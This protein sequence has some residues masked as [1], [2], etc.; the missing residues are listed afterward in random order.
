MTAPVKR[1]REESTTGIAAI[2]ALRRGARLS[3]ALAACQDLLRRSPTEPRLLLLAATICRDRR[4][5][6][7]AL[8]FLDRIV[9]AKPAAADIYCEVARLRRQCG[10]KAGALDAYRD[11]LAADPASATAHA[12]LAELLTVDGQAEE[13]IYHL[14]IAIAVDPARLDA[15]ET[16]ATLME[17]HGRGTEAATLRQETMYRARRRI[18]AEYTRIRT[19][20]ASDSARALQRLRLS[21][22]HALLIFGTAG[23]GLAKFEESEGDG[24]KA[25]ETYGEVLSVLAEGAD[26]A[27]TVP[28]LRRAFATASL[29]FA[30][31]HYELALLHERR[32]AAD[33]AIFHVEE[34][35]R[36]HGSPWDDAYARLGSL[37][38]D[39]AGGITAIRQAVAGATTQPSRPAAYPITRWDVARQARPWLSEVARARAAPPG[40][41]G[42]HVA[43]LAATPDDIEVGFAIA[44]ILAAR[45][46]RIDLIW[47]PGLRFEGACDPD[48]GFDAWDETLMAQAVETLA[49]ADLP[50]GLRLVDLRGLDAADADEAMEQEADRLAALDAG[51]RRATGTVYASDRPAEVQHRNRTQRNLAA[52]RRLAGYLAGTK[53]HH[54]LLVNGDMT[55]SGCAFWV[56]RRAGCPAVVWERCP[57]RAS[58]VIVSSNR[59]RADR[60]YTSLW[61]ADEPHD[62]TPHR[63]ERAMAWLANRSGGDYRLVTPRKHYVPAP[64]SFRALADHRLDSV[65]PVVVLFGDRAADGEATREGDAFADSKT[66]ILRNI[67]FFAQHPEWQLIVRLYPQDGPSG[68]RNA[69]REKQSD[70]PRNVSFVESSDPKLDY[71]LL[72]VAQL[73]LFRTNPIGLEIAMMGV[74]AIAAGQPFF[75][76]KGFTRDTTDDESYFRTVRRALEN[77]DSIAMTDREIELAWCFADMCVHAAPKPFPWSARNFWRDVTEDW[78]LRRVLGDAGRVRFGP[79]FAALGG[80]VAL[81]DGVVGNIG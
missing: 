9:A 10:S 68:V 17:T 18:A 16:L 66:W 28:A 57:D 45:G 33:R 69:L 49:A 3:E 42:N 50:D 74:I 20:A 7:E 58:A 29:A 41:E 53:P 12:E 19:P 23:I 65:R 27:R 70:L 11:A 25:V 63:R 81:A 64:R 22:A 24:D 39:R 79:T 46:H 31:C 76:G 77:P 80:E 62:L 6:T 56:A 40:G 30:Q 71:Q 59:T 51:R 1:N 21:W 43:M 13:A 37:V 73:G 55:E 8:S 47:W 54:M 2:E 44:C 61:K 34:A 52:M 48:P 26:Q 35:L 15:R 36:A 72:E 32:G 67:D 14:E 60:D 78:P 75:C 4:Q 5:Y 38:K